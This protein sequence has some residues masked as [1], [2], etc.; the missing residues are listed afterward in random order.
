MRAGEAQVRRRRRAHGQLRVLFLLMKPRVIFNLYIY[1]NLVALLEPA[2]RPIVVLIVWRTLRRT[3][4]RRPP[5]TPLFCSHR[6]LCSRTPHQPTSFPPDHIILTHLS[7]SVYACL[8]AL[9]GSH[10]P[11]PQLA[12][13][14]ILPDAAFVYWVHRGAC[15]L[16]QSHQSASRHGKANKHKAHTRARVDAFRGRHGTKRGAGVSTSII[17]R[18]GLRSESRAI[19]S[20]QEKT[21]A[22][23]AL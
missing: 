19:P 17:G 12:D 22:K 6:T 20:G 15:M 9:S 11:G 16:R 4:L 21:R 23:K 10:T 18:G 1:M 14:V 8:P 5:P 13:L 2:V 3:L 7:G